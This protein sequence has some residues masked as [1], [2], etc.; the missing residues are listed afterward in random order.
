MTQPH[1]ILCVAVL[2]RDASSAAGPSLGAIEASMTR[3]GEP[4]GSIEIDNY[5][6]PGW[7]QDPDLY[8]LVVKPY[9]RTCHLSEGGNADFGTY[10]KF[11]AEASTT[12]DLV[13][14]SHDMAH[15]EVP[16][17]RFWLKDFVAQ[18]KLRD[19]LKSQGQSGC[20]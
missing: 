18:Q 2:R 5:V 7:A 20:P 11:V 12:N 13:C 4:T 6:P 15:A 14:N 10:Q 1:K 16:Y 9:C 3:K 17:V 19:F 8:N